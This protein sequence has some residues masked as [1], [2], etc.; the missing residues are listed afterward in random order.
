MEGD[1]LFVKIILL[2]EEVFFYQIDR[3]TIFVEFV[4]L[5]KLVGEEKI[6]G[7]GVL[8]FEYFEVSFGF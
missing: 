2:E 3:E 6:D 4:V 8:G 1:F 7:H 5:E